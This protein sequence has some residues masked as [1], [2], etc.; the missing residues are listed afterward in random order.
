MIRLCLM[1]HAKA[2]QDEGGGPD[3]ERRLTGRGEHAATAMARWMAE[4]GWTPDLALCSSARRT[5]QTLAFMLPELGGKPPQV[6]YADALYL[7]E[8]EA[9]LRRIRRVPAGWSSVLVIG[10]NPGLHA[11]AVALLDES[12]GKPARR[13]REAMPTAALACFE[14]EDGWAAL[15][16][17]PARL[18]HFVTPKDIAHGDG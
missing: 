16:R 7:A 14:L 5:R 1:R 9:L 6:H 8:P 12:S 4:A 18:V 15:G 10:H 13:L 17:E 11:L 3:R 2:E